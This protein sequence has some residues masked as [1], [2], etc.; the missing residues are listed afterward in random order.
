MRGNFLMPRLCLIGVTIMAIVSTFAATIRASAQSKETPQVPSPEQV[1]FDQVR[2]RLE[3][4][5]KSLDG[6]GYRR[7][8]LEI[9]AAVGKGGMGFQLELVLGKSYAIV[10]ACDEACKKLEL[11][12]HDSAGAVV[13]QSAETGGIIVVAGTAGESGL[14]YGMLQVAECGDDQCQVGLSVLRKD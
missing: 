5:Y 11:V 6:K 4:E 7:E 13:T 3:A 8:A 10:G 2:G 12:V 9:V 14:H 1:R